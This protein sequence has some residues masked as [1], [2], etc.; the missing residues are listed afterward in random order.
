[1]K[2]AVGMLAFIDQGT[3]SPQQVTVVQ[4]LGEFMLRILCVV[5]S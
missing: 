2:E 4:D 1:M 5:W 3:E